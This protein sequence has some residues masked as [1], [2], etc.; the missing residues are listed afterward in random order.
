MKSWLEAKERQGGGWVGGARGEIG[1]SM[2]M[3][4]AHQSHQGS[5]SSRR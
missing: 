5:R 3:F 2:L 4:R 1:R